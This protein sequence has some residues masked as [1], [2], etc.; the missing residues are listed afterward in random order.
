MPLSILRNDIR[1]IQSDILVNPTDAVFS[2][3]GGVDRTVLEEA[4]EELERKCR[5]LPE[6][7]VGQAVLTQAYDFRNYR[8]IIHVYG[9]T[10]IDGEHGEEGLLRKCYENCLKIA[11]DSSFK[12]ITFPLISSGTFGFPK[13][14][15]LRI[16]VDTIAAFLLEEELDVNLLVYDRESYD[17]SSKLFVGVRDYLLDN[18]E[19]EK[20]RRTVEYRSM[21][22]DLV[23]RKKKEKITNMAPPLYGSIPSDTRKTKEE[24]ISDEEETICY[25]SSSYGP[26][27]IIESIE[28][29]PDR[30]FGEYLVELI[31]E[32]NMKD[33]DVY[34]RANINRDVFNKII[35]NK[36]KIPKK[37]TCVALAIGLKL[38]LKE[39][40]ELLSKAGY[41]LSNSFV[42][43]QIIIYCIRNREYNVFEINEVLYENDQETLG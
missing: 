26:E 33:A 18:A 17:T 12:S 24:I 23:Q 16:A 42:F 30:S 22:S 25:N 38:D 1:S 14:K 31:D 39:T 37:K 11:K 8:C 36:V 34:K 13:G 40:N 29:E 20:R 32:R 3:S 43:D 41:V 4:G 5:E 10:Y 28:F 6:L 27:S 21:Q 9:P 2:H 7:K 15:A 35:N 19:K